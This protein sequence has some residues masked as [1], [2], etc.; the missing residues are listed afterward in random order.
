MSNPFA[1][2]GEDSF[3]LW[4][5]KS[6]FDGVFLSGVA[7]GILFTITAQTLLLFSQ[8]PKDKTPRLLIAYII[9]IFV[10]ASVGFGGN[11]KFN[12]MTYIDDRN[13]PG[14]PNA[15]TVDFYSTLV[16]MLSF[17]A[18]ILMSWMADGLVLWRFTLIWEVKYWLSAFPLLMFLGSVGSSIA[19]FI[20]IARHR[21]TFWSEKSMQFGLAYWSLSIALNIILTLSIVARIWLVRRQVHALAGDSPRHSA[22]HYVSIAAMLIESAALYATWSM[23]FL[24]CYA[25]NT[26]LQNLLLPPLGQVQGIAPL[27]ILFRVAQGRAWSQDTRTVTINSAIFARSQGIIPLSPS[28]DGF[29]GS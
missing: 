15:Y 24:I 22:I 29:R 6:N 18:Y 12:Q 5:E 23:V 25:R 4:L 26:P 28:A 19:L 20:S 14:G 17:G 16:N 11:A 8:L 13:Y 2:L 21:D 10:L 1:P 27:L 3:D 7:Y 9:A